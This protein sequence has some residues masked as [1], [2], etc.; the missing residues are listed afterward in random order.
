MMRKSSEVN[1]AMRC[2]IMRK[3][4]EGVAVELSEVNEAET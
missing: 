1:V 2:E 3:K 4:C